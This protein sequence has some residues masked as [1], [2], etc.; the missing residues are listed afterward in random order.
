MSSDFGSMVVS[1]V[2]GAAPMGGFDSTFLI[3]AAGELAQRGVSTYEQ[4]QAAD[5]AKAQGTAQ[6]SRAIAADGAWASAEQMLDLS[7]Q[8][9]DVQKI[10]A[11]TAMAQSADAAADAAGNGLPADGVAKRVANAQAAMNQAAQASLSNPKDAPAAA[12]MRAWQKV[13]AR[14]GVS[15]SG[16]AGGGGSS[17]GGALSHMGL[18]S[19]PSFFTRSYAGVPVWGWGLGGLAVVGGLTFLLMRRR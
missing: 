12:L 8:S 3:N 10:A 9:G 5:K 11:A 2:M 14:A 1:E 7:R 4:K 19:G 16:D 15:S 18:G 13:A 6:T 17:G